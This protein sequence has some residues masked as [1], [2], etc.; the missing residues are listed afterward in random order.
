MLSSHVT[1][2]F[3]LQCPGGR[4]MGVPQPHRYR[5]ASPKGL[6]VPHMCPAAPSN[7]F[8]GISP[9]NPGTLHSAHLPLSTFSH[10]V[11]SLGALWG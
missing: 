10:T 5:P 2:G 3:P 8:W 11:P 6:K 1:L 7:I 9:R 4:E